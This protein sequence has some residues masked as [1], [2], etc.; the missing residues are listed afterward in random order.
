M[1]LLYIA[2][3]ANPHC[4]DYLDAALTSAVFGLP[5][6][7][8]FLGEGVAQL[9]A[10]APGAT[11]GLTNP[12]DELLQYGVT[13]IYVQQQGLV[14]TVTSRPSDSRIT[15]LSNL[16]ISRLIARHDQVFNF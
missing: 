4:R 16:D 9:T 11:E 12:V 15:E 3:G 6:A 1:K 5:V 10:S 2:S 8:L 7:V 13:D 14:D